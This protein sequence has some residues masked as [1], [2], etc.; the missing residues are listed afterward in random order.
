M[1]DVTGSYTTPFELCALICLVGSVASFLC[2][3]P[4][5]AELTTTADA[6]TSTSTA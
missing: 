2:V 4:R 1:T 3:V 6:T 5:P